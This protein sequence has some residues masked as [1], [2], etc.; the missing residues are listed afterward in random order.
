MSNDRNYRQISNA[1]SAAEDTGNVEQLNGLHDVIHTGL[2]TGKLSITDAAGL[3]ADLD[4][5]ISAL[6]RDEYKG[7][8]AAAEG[9]ERSLDELENA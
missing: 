1:I 2:M 5:A 6:E 8:Y 7:D 9:R 4:I 3:T